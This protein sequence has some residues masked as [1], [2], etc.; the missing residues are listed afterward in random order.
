M[1]MFSG[2][3]PIRERTNLLKISETPD[4][5]L[6]RCADDLQLLMGRHG[7]V[8]DLNRVVLKH[9]LDRFVD[10]RYSAQVGDF[11]RDLGRAGSNGG[12]VKTSLLIGFEMNVAHD[13]AG[14]HGADAIRLPRRIGQMLKVHNSTFRKR[15]A[16]VITD[17]ELNVMAAAAMMG[18]SR[19]PNTG[20]STPA[21]M[22][23]P[24]AL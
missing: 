24:R 23:T 16:F 21:A 18:L 19:S 4:R 13:E 15:N 12:Y 7:D 5:A 1:E 17:T 3:E 9:V 11:L 14:A 6:N 10:A 20:Y 22:G 2:W 8:E